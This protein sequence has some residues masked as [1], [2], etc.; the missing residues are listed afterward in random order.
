MGIRDTGRYRIPRTSETEFQPGSRRRVLVNRLGI[1]GKKEM[2]R[3]EYEAL[4]NAQR[5]MLHTVG[6]STRFT[7]KIL[8]RMHLDWLGE[9]YAWAGD[10]RTVNLT[11]S[12]FTWPPASRI[13]DNM[14]RFESEL[15]RRHTPCR[16]NSLSR[17]AYSISVVHAE[18]LLIHPF[19]EGNGRLARWLADLMALQA[20]LPAPHYAFEGRGCRRHYLRYLNAVKVGYLQELEPLQ[21]FFVEALECGLDAVG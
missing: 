18:L 11:K 21:A 8:R 14:T 12:G 10:Y 9:I 19:R 3:V 5:R 4:L 17:V 1:A 7:A 20:G 6:K 13:P 15:L 2:D 16:P